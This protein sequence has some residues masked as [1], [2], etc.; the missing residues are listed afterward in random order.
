MVE[1]LVLP[2]LL[3][4][5]GVFVVVVTA[6][7]TMKD[8]GVHVLLMRGNCLSAIWTSLSVAF[9]GREGI[10]KHITTCVI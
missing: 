6:L 8:T 7:S 5:N 1:L 10:I 4:V 3:T 2:L 9:T